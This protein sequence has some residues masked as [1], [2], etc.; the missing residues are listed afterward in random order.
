[1]CI[2]D[3]IF[4]LGSGLIEVLVSPI[5][6]ACPTDNKEK[7]MSL[8][9]SFYCWGHMAV[10]LV[11]TLFFVLFGIQ[12]WKILALIWALVPL[13]SLIH[14]SMCIRDSH[15]VVAGREHADVFQAPRVG[16]LFAGEHG[17]VGERHV[18][19]G[20]ADGHLGR[21]AAVIYGQFAPGPVSYTHLDVS[22]RPGCCSPR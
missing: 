16:E 20:D 22:K 5:M 11:S 1:M 19:I 9:H 4:S 15:D 21:R 17:L 3:S 12:N 8:L 10:V 18:R 7:A 14:I 13:L 2:R 6:E